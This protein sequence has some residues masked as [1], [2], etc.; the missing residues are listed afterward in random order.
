MPWIKKSMPVTF[1]DEELQVIAFLSASIGGSEDGYRG[2][3]DKVFNKLKIY[4]GNVC[5]SDWYDRIRRKI[6]TEKK[7]ANAIYFLDG[8]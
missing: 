2:V 8:K 3:M 5:G 1:T 7:Y 6:D 4:F